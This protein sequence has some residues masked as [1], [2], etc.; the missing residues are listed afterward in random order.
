MVLNPDK[1][2]FM[3]FGVDNELQ[4]NCVEVKLLNTVTKK[5]Y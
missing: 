2:L 4:I 3:L 1:C 5:K